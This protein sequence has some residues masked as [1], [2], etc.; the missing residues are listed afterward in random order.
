MDLE[1]TGPLG[2]GVGLGVKNEAAG[3]REVGSRGAGTAEAADNMDAVPQGSCSE[4]CP[5]PRHV[6]QG[7][8]VKVDDAVISH[9]AREE[10]PIPVHASHQVNLNTTF[11]FPGEPVLSH[12]P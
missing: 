4:G 7:L 11:V 3:F 5:W 2:P 10:G 8:V 9:C 6:R 12:N 1:E